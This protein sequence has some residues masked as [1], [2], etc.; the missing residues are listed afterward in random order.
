VDHLYDGS[1]H[2]AIPVAR[3]RVAATHGAG[4]THSAALAAALA[5]GLPLAA[6]A[7]YAAGVAGEAV[8]HGLATLG[9][10]DGPVHALSHYVFT[11]GM[12]KTDE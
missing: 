5:A 1:R 2:L 10:G 11:G 7:R 12:E 6:A 9:A 4:C 3:H 8:A